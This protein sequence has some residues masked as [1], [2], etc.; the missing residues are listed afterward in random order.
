MEPERPPHPLRQTV[1]WH[2]ST[3]ALGLSAH[4]C[5]GPCAAQP[6]SVFVDPA[7][8]YAGVAGSV[9]AGAG[10]P[11]ARAPSPRSQPHARAAA[12]W[13]ESVRPAGWS[14]TDM[15]LRTDRV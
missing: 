1:E 13:G 4:G 5:R 12:E 8:M 2:P 10:R 7:Q 11:P 3:K 15:E 6:I 14:R 9:P